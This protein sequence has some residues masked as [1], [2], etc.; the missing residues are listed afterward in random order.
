MFLDPVAY[1]LAYPIIP[2]SHMT[3]KSKNT[4]KIHIYIYTYIYP[5]LLS[6]KGGVM[7]SLW[8]APYMTVAIYS[9]L[10]TVN[11]ALH[12]ILHVSFTDLHGLCFFHTCPF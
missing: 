8:G 2:K 3:K 11:Y 1:F 5:S 12:R 4:P 6:P 9:R 7:Y 10:L